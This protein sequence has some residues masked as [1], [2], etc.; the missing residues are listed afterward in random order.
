[1][2]APYCETHGS[3]VLLPMSAIEAL[4]QGTNGLE[5]HF[6]CSCGSSGVWVA[7][8]RSAAAF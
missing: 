3:R 6:R 2:F 1:M 4:V 8:K 7:P 5:A